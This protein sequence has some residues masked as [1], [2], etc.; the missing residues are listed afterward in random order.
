S[1]QAAAK[2]DYAQSIY[3][4]EENNQAKRDETSK[5]LDQLQE[6][7]PIVKDIDERKRHLQ[8]LQKAAKQAGADL[9]NVKGRLK[10]KNEEVE[11]LQ[12]KINTSERAVGQ[13]FEKNEKLNNMREQAKV[14]KRFFTVKEKQTQLDQDFQAKEK[15]YQT[16]KQK[17]DA[18]EQAWMHNQASILAS[19]LHDGEPCPVCGSLEHPNKAGFEDNDSTKE[20]LET[21]KKELDEKDR[22]YRDAIANWKSNDTRLKE[23]QEELS[24]YQINPRDAEAVYQTVET[25]GK[26]LRGEVD[27]LKKQQEALNRDKET[28]TKETEVLKQLE[29]KKEQLEKTYYEKYAA[30]EKEKA[31]YDERLRNIP[32]EVRILSELE[33]QIKQTSDLKAQLEKTWEDAQV[34]LQEAKDEQTKATADL[35]NKRKQLDDISSKREKAVAEFKAALT[36][37]GFESEEAYQQAKIPLAEREKLKESIQTFNEN[38]S[39]LTQVVNDLRASLKDKQKI[40]LA[41]IQTQLDQ[42]KQA[43]ESALK[44]LNLSKDYYQDASDLKLNIMEANEQVIAREKELTTI[45]D[46]Y[47]VLRGQNDQKIS[48]ERYLQIEYLERIIEAANGRLKDLSNGQFYLMRSDRQESHGKQ[49]GL[50]LDVYDAYTGQTRDVKT[51]SGGEKFNASLCLALG[52]SDVIQSFQGNISIDTMFIDEG[53][54]SLDEETL[55]KSIETLIDLQQSGRMIGVISHVQDLKTMFPARLDVVK[56][57]EG[58]SRTEFVVT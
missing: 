1:K 49:S 13:L 7:V 4:Q 22:L 42:L 47:D 38:R 28:Y 40:D 46:L 29:T 35:T 15:A 57:K 24:Q 41:A 12:Q 25:K 34:K 14:L 51:L 11:T 10:T 43:Y 30:Y 31:V 17:Y 56:T 58:S 55:N 54:G 2:L 8:E 32:E 21:L 39:A 3:K 5:K 50:A 26:Q 23:T 20:Q 36:N 16:I 19:H 9:E 6:F 52:M 18:Y 45:T 44:Q 53:F 37:A 48:F 33:K 27:A